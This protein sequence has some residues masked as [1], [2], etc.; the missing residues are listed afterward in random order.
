[1]MWQGLILFHA[2]ILPVVLWVGALGR[3]R[4]RAAV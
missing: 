4:L 1:M 3:S 2:A